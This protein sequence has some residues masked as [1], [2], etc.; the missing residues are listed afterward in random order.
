MTIGKIAKTL[1][2]AK[3]YGVTL[4]DNKGKGALRV[5]LKALFLFRKR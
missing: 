2:T 1:L 3:K 5:I 4:A